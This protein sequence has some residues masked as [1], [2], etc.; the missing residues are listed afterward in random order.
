MGFGK[1]IPSGWPEYY[2]NKIFNH[3]AFM[4]NS[5]NY[6]HV[7]NNPIDGFSDISGEIDSNGDVSNPNGTN[8]NFWDKTVEITGY[9]YPY[10]IF[11][12]GLGGLAIGLTVAIAMKS[13]KKSYILYPL[14]G[15]VSGLGLGGVATPPKKI[16]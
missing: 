1:D 3:N 8:I 5:D 15:L 13:D 7:I 11:M 10:S 9:K 16:T 2:D 6:Q 4:D 14:I 12:I